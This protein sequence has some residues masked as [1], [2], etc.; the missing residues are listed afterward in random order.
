MRRTLFRKEKRIRIKMKI[1][2]LLLLF[3]VLLSSLHCCLSR[4]RGD[5][6]SPEETELSEESGQSGDSVDSG[7]Y[8][9]SSESGD[10]ADSENSEDSGEGRE[11]RRRS[12]FDSEIDESDESG[13]SEDS[14]ESGD[15][16]ESGRDGME[17]LLLPGLSLS[18]TLLPLMDNYFMD[19]FPAFNQR[20]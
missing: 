2:Y 18:P 14:G 4:P 9:Y 8:S 6:S 19:I 15:F 12:L 17:V 7:D 16:Q 11:I 5:S 10:S 3:C 1:S 13:D 20:P